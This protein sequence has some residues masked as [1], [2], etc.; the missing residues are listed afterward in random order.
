MCTQYVFSES[1]SSIG[2]GE[3]TYRQNMPKA[4]NILAKINIHGHAMYDVCF[5]GGEWETHNATRITT[6]CSQQTGMTR[7]VTL[8]VDTH[9]VCLLKIKT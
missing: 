4:F 8:N 9:T 2:H 6:Q 7:L 5:S 1:L 3:H